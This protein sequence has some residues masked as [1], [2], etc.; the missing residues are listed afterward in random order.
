MRAD[1]QRKVCSRRPRERTSGLHAFAAYK[2]TLSFSFFFS[3]V[4][5]FLAFGDVYIFFFFSIT[6]TTKKKERC[7]RNFAELNGMG[8]L[9]RGCNGDSGAWIAGWTPRSGVYGLSFGISNRTLPP[10]SG[11]NAGGGVG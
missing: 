11:V 3:E 9:F 8:L 7:L 4:L 1:R 5:F 6:M 2:C 10:R